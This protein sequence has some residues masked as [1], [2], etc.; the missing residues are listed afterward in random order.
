MNNYKTGLFSIILAKIRMSYNYMFASCLNCLGMNVSKK[1]KGTKI[2]A[3]SIINFK[4]DYM[5]YIYVNHSKY[6]YVVS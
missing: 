5:C 3:H 6:G 1:I 2:V 4:L